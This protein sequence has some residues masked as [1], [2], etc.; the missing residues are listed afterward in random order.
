MQGMQLSP[1]L[2]YCNRRQDSSH[3]HANSMAIKFLLTKAHLLPLPC[4]LSGF[5]AR[6]HHHFLERWKQESK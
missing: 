3:Y 2:S 1:R 5:P 6:R 4:S